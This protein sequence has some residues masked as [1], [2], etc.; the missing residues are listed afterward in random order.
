MD[1]EMTMFRKFHPFVFVAAASICC[2]IG[3]GLMIVKWGM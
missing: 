1:K 2:W 3:I